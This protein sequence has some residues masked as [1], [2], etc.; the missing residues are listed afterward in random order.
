[1]DDGELALERLRAERLALHLD[2]AH[3]SLRVPH[4]AA[5]RVHAAADALGAEADPPRGHGGAQQ[6]VRELGEQDQLGRPGRRVL[7]DARLQRRQLRAQVGDPGGT[8]RGT[9]T[10]RS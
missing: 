1:M 5:Q 6:L 10:G 9:V 4:E 2:D 8:E 7:L 3:A